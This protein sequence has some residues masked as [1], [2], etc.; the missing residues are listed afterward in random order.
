MLSQFSSDNKMKV[1]GELY[2]FPKD[3]YPIGRLDY[4]SEGLLILSNDKKLFDRLLNPKYKH[5]RSYWVQVEGQM[6]IFAIEDLKRGVEIKIDSKPYFTKRAQAEIIHEPNRLPERF[7]PVRYRKTI[8]TS[9]INI[10]L[11]EGKNRQ[12]RKMTAQVGFPCLRL[13]RHKIENLELPELIPGKVWEMNKV[14]IYQ[15]LDLR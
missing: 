10:S 8:P 2:E 1:L 15:K 7:P 6:N 4:D 3:V 5:T 9:W 11:T 13:I 14:E 12:V